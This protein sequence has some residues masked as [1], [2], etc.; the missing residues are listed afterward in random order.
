MAIQ[1]RYFGDFI[2]SQ[3]GLLSPL[4]F[5]LLLMA[6]FLPLKKNYEGRHWVLTYLFFT[7]FPVAAAFALLSLHTRVEGNWAAPGLL[8]AAVI[9]AAATARQFENYRR[10][11]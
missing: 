11:Y 4:V 6:W 10:C 2:G 5:V 1:F 9:T 8:G 7:S 3:A